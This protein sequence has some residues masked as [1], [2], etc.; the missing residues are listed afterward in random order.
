MVLARQDAESGAGL[1]RISSSSGKKKD[2]SKSQSSKV[3]ALNLEETPEKQ[4]NKIR[5]GRIL[6][7]GSVQ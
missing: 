1:G 5:M 2:V 7:L 3:C 4:I 6:P